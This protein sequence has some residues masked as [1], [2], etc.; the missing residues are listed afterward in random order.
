LHYSPG[1]IQTKNMIFLTIHF[2][3]FIFVTIHLWFLA[4]VRSVVVE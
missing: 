2:F 3:V 1:I 4:V